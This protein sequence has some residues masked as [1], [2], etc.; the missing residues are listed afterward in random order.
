MPTFT[1]HAPRRRIGDSVDPERFVFVRDGFYFWAFLLA[2]LW[3]IVRRLWLALLGYVVVNGAIGVALYVAGAPGWARF[4]VAFAV[5]LLVG[6]EAATLWR[7]TLDRRGW[8]MLGF[9]VGD[10][11]ESAE[12]RFFSGWEKQMAPPEPPPAAPPPPSP[13]ESAPPAWRNQAPEHP[14]L[15]LFP[16]PEN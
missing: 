9:A 14:I 3:L 10:N 5:A 15:G 8:K 12:Q 7:W 11:L 6:F 2:P 13:P 16:Q 1:V 4:L